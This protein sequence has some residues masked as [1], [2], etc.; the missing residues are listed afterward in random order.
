MTATCSKNCSVFENTHSLVVMPTVVTNNIWIT[1]NS[2]GNFS[3][4]CSRVRLKCLALVR[5]GVLVTPTLFHLYITSMRRWSDDRTLFMSCYCVIIR[6]NDN[7]G[8]YAHANTQNWDSTHHFLF[9]LTEEIIVQRSAV[10]RT[11]SINNL[12]V[13]IIKERRLLKGYT[14]LKEANV[15]HVTQYRS[16]QQSFSPRPW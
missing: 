12:F 11:V 4:F 2:S 7:L 15:Y 1:L 5:R 3:L 14:A 6:G 9:W 10:F 16:R 13:S 8:S